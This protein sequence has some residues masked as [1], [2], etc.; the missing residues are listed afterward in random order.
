MSAAR[1]RERLARQERSKGPDLHDVFG[2]GLPMVLSISLAVDGLVGVDLVFYNPILSFPI[3]RG[4]VL[5]VLGIAI[6]FVALPTFTWAAY[7]TG[8]YVFSKVASERTLL[9]R[10][11]YRFVRHPIYLGFGLTGVGLVLLAQ[12]FLMLPV[13]ILFFDWGW[14]KEDTELARAYGEQYAEY[15][16]RTGAFFP[17]IR[18]R[19]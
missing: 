12:N 16:A 5:Q 18:G 15:R 17:R 11:P 1:R 19:V 14:R 9:T 2:F 7:L 3:P 8:K 13:L 4:D 6:L 10:G